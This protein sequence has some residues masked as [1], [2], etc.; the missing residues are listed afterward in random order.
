MNERPVLIE[1]GPGLWVNPAAV[2]AVTTPDTPPGQAPQLGI[3]GVCI[4][5]FGVVAVR[6]TPATVA[7]KINGTPP[8]H[9]APR[10]AT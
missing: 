2:D 6:S 9:E 7:A 10:L 4:R 5:G 3:C 8:P 1:I